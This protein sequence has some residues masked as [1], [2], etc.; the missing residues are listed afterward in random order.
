MKE[1]KKPKTSIIC[2]TN[3]DDAKC[4][5]TLGDDDEMNDEFDYTAFTS[6]AEACVACSIPV[7]HFIQ[8]F[9]C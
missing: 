2:D 7:L 8:F 9:M 3:A 1:T 5:S 6:T 4:V